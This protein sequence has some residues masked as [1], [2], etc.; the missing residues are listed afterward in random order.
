MQWSVAQVSGLG[1]NNQQ[2]RRILASQSETAEAAEQ[3]YLAPTQTSLVRIK[4][5][6]NDPDIVSRTVKD[7]LKV[8]VKETLLSWEPGYRF[9][10]SSSSDMVFGS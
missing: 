4:L 7:S 2:S 1:Q 5:E 6:F 8:E 9:A 10:N 3:N